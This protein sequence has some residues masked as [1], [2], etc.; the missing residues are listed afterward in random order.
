MPWIEADLRIISAS[1]IDGDL[2][3]YEFQL[4]CPN[5]CLIYISPAVGARLIKSSLHQV[6]PTRTQFSHGQP[7]FPATYFNLD[8][9]ENRT[10]LDFTLDLKLSDAITTGKKLNVGILAQ[11]TAHRDNYCADFGKL[12][13]DLPDWIT[14]TD[15]IATFHSYEF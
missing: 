2:L 9:T 3:R 11:Y 14:T 10:D 13:N 4:T 1:P 8:R 15:M 5:N 7:I 12:L 6:I